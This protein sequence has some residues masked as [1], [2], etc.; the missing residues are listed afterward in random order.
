MLDSKAIQ[1]I[2]IERKL[3]GSSVVDSIELYA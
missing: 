1:A 3:D 2:D